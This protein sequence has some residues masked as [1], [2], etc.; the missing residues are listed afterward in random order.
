MPP[1]IIVIIPTLWTLCINAAVAHGDVHGAILTLT[2]ALKAS[3]S[4][5]VPLLLERAGLYFTDEDYER[6][7]TDLE[8][9][10]AAEPENK[11][12]L[13][14]KGRIYRLTHRPQLALAALKEFR[15]KYPA[16]AEAIREEALNLRDEGNIPAAIV[17]LDAAIAAAAH[18]SPDLLFERLEIT[19]KNGAGGPASALE[20]LGTVLKSHPLPILEEEALKLEIQLNLIP[21]AT[22]R[23]DKMA[24]RHPRPARLLI[25]K[26]ELLASQN[27]HS[28]AIEA[29][30][31]AAA[32]ITRL[33]EHLRQVADTTGLTNRIN[34]ILK[35]TP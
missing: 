26:A 19:R 24:A 28:A 9:A 35:T 27:Q 21:A 8:A 34:T 20:W 32:A 6:A 18:L 13:L 1:R 30:G 10:R 16:N 22:A 25:Q 4:A 23:I 7:L 12:P 29:A 14:M 31:A 3:P 17:G 5:P 15:Q 11:A 33:P 2:E